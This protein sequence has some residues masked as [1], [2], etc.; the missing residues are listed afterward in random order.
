MQIMNTHEKI[1]TQIVA[2]LFNTRADVIRAELYR[3]L[4]LHV[5]TELDS[6]CTIDELVDLVAYTI[7]SQVKKTTSLQTIILDE[8][9]NL[10]ERGIVVYKDGLYSL[11]KLEETPL[12]NKVG[13][14]QLRKAVY[15]EVSNIALSINP[16]I[17]KS[18][19]DQLFE[20]YLKV[21][22]IVAKERMLHLAKV[23][24]FNLDSMDFKSLSNLV[25]NAKLEY[26]LEK[27]I[28]GNEFINKCFINPSELLSS[29]AFT[30]IQVNIIMQLL[31]WDPALEY[32]QQN[33][34]RGKTL[35][36]DSSILFGLMIKSDPIHDFIS[37]LIF[38]SRK[39]LG[40]NIVVHEITLKEYDFVIKGHSEDFAFQKKDLKQLALIAKQDG[41][42]PRD[43]LED[44]I[45]ADY[46]CQSIDHVDAG[47]WQRYTNNVSVDAL[48]R[49]LKELGVIVDKQNAFVPTDDFEAIK[50]NIRKA[51]IDRIKRRSSKR[52]TSKGD[53]T[54]DAQMFYLLKTK[55]KKL[56]GKLSFGYDKY[57]LTMDGS[58]IDFGQYQG[59]PWTETYFL[60][61]HQWY[62]MA[63]PFLRMKI[64]DNPLA[65]KSFASMAF[66][67]IF[68]RLEKLVPLS[69]FGYIFKHGG[70]DLS[71]KSVQTVV[72]ALY[73]ERLVE[74][75]DPA[76][77]DLMER[78]EAKVRLERIIADKMID[79]KNLI[80]K[81]AGERDALKRKKA[82]LEA[83]IASKHTEL[84]K[85]ENEALTKEAEIS[86]FDKNIQGKQD[87]ADLY[88]SA[89]EI[90]KRV[91]G[92]KKK[93]LK[94]ITEFFNDRLRKAEDEKME[95]EALLSN[96]EERLI[97]MEESFD[98]IS[99]RLKKS[100]DERE[101]EQKKRRQQLN[102]LK[103]TTVTGLMMF[104]IL[105]SIVL[106][107]QIDANTYILIT[108]VGIMIL[109][110]VLYHWIQNA[111]WSFIVFGIGLLLS[112]GL[113]FSFYRLEAVLWI[114][115][116]AWE[117]L[118]LGTE[119]IFKRQVTK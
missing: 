2:F 55:R 13:E 48:K 33:V 63:F 97:K 56:S 113:L 21:C 20:F 9:N 30:L 105:L 60:F 54:H 24:E 101:N 61:P 45:F 89:E 110:V 95:R 86:N 118:V 23:G 78:E 73:E 77:K 96:Q 49:M 111:W 40:V 106:L 4:C 29:Y 76:N 34:L 16:D 103:N 90:K 52:L 82:E 1:K 36:L 46:L 37:N 64:S 65:A 94:E 67:N 43:I 119:Q 66:S 70:T 27:I 102:T 35:Y 115:P 83:G 87:L 93:E 68:P 15:D 109:G 112:T 71:L 6:P 59:I 81:L 19:L 80:A 84:N 79:E 28:D 116:M 92:E 104:G 98:L 26:E 62:E 50:E 17:S 10:I 51:S 47:S 75:L 107:N 25:E 108:S 42:S 88:Q 85:L 31:T 100:E 7:D 99:V 8:I 14:E 74:R 57:L 12:P 58:L 41:V 114:I 117:I 38:A 3:A 11:D 22:D 39:E 69:I 91:E 18:R 44:H 53:T 5:L 32:I 72:D